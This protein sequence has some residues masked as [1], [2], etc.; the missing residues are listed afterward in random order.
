MIIALCGNKSDLYAEEE[1]PIEKGREFAM[2]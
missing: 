2:A 1:V